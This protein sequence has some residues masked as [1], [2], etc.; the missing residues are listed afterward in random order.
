[1]N[2]SWYVNTRE[3]YTTIKKECTDIYNNKDETEKDIESKR[4]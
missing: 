3:C 1:M 2:K 4:S